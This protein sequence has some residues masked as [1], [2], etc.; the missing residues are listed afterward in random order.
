MAGRCFSITDEGFDVADSRDELIEAVARLTDVINS[1]D[2]N[3]L[4]PP[5]FGFF[6]TAA[7]HAAPTRP[8]MPSAAT[9]A[10]A[11]APASHHGP[12]PTTTMRDR[13]AEDLVGWRD[14]TREL[15]DNVRKQPGEHGLPGSSQV[16]RPARDASPG[17]QPGTSQVERSES[18]RTLLGVLPT[19][20]AEGI[21]KAWDKSAGWHRLA[22]TFDTMAKQGQAGNALL[23]RQARGH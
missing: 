1:V 17:R 15:F 4:A 13:T 22:D 5:T 16:E 10:T 6:P 3:A 12:L 2:A 14:A 20:I 21:S 23:R 19:P 9:A 7:A 8:A 11:S 18:L